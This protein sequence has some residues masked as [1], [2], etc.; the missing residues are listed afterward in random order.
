MTPLGNLRTSL[1][2]ASSTDARQGG[3]TRR[4]DAVALGLLCVALAVFGGCASEPEALLPKS[5]VVPGDVDLSGRWLMQDDFDDMQRRIQRA[6]RETDDLDERDFLRR[7]PSSATVRGS[8]RSRRDVGGLVHV[9]LE[10]AAVLKITQTADGLFVGFDR[11]IVEEYRFGEARPI[12][13]GG[14]IAR[15][16]SGWENDGYVIETLGNS[17]MK[18]TERY[19]LIGE[20]ARLS[21]EIVLR[22]K[23]LQQVAIVQTFAREGD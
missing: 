1:T 2:G 9:F 12:N 17:G 11:S 3:C 14:A 21:R 23:S 8:R 13:V 18:L 4:S 22:S 7:P 15:R 10:N 6:I 20:G 16:V 5:S 19:R